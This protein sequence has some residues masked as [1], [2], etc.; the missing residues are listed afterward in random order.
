MCDRGEDVSVLGSVPKA[1]HSICFDAQLCNVEHDLR[2]VLAPAGQHVTI[3][4]VQNLPSLINLRSKMTEQEYIG[5]INRAC[6]DMTCG[7]QHIQSI[8]MDTTRPTCVMILVD[9]FPPDDSPWWCLSHAG[10][11]PDCLAS[12]Q[13]LAFDPSI[14]GCAFHAFRPGQTLCECLERPCNEAEFLSHCLLP[15]PHQQV[16]VTDVV[17]SYASSIVNS[18]AP[19]HGA[20]HS[21]VKLRANN[22]YLV[23]DKV[24]H[25]FSRELLAKEQGTAA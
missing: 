5:L 4:R 19:M 15:F 23:V 14:G 2:S 12:L 8:Q 18:H 13:L 16:S 3:H 10:L 7:I 24:L 11:D 20:Q 1:R 22:A 25:M 9:S 21:T 6:L 17:L